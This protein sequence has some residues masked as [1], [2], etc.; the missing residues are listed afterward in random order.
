[1]SEKHFQY[2]NL[3]NKNG[4]EVLITN[5][6]GRIISILVPDSEGKKIDIIMGNESA[7]GFLESS[8][9]YFGAI[10]GPYAGRIANGLFTLD[11]KIYSLSVN[12]GSNT[13][14]SGEEGFHNQIWEANLLS[15]TEL[16]LTLYKRDN[17]FGFPGNLEIK[18]TYTLLENNRLEMDYQAITDKKTVLNL[19][20]HAFF[21]LNGVEDGSILDHLIKINADQYLPLN[22]NLIPLGSVESVAGGPFDFREF[23][24]LGKDIFNIHPQVKIGNGYDHCFVLN[25]HAFETPVAQVIGEKTGIQLE[26]FTTEPGLV[27]YSGNFFKGENSLK[28]GYQDHFRSSFALE[29][30]HFAD[31][32]NQPQFPS[33][34][35]NPNESYH[36]ITQYGFKW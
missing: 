34:E 13:L 11:E 9:A 16:L 1:M 24:A 8:E 10:I 30:Q 29:T 25:P 36:S 35:L 7:E 2:F 20:N 14:H 17:G 18:V 12:N 22:E 15:E 23:K 31:S 4:L 19:T 6:G 27:F 3:K 28:G 21:N 32:P 5:L 26:I 33:T